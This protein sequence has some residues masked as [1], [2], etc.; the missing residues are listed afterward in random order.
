MS[1]QHGDALGTGRDPRIRYDYLSENG[2]YSQLCGC[3]MWKVMKK[4]TQDFLSSDTQK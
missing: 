2:V 3:A 4:K 1:L